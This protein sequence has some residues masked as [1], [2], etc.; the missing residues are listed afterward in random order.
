MYELWMIELVMQNHC[1]WTENVIQL[2]F[3]VIVLSRDTKKLWFLNF[4]WSR[5]TQSKSLTAIY[6]MHICLSV[7]F[8]YLVTFGTFTKI[9]VQQPWTWPE[10]I[11]LQIRKI[12]I[13][14]SK[15]KKWHG[16]MIVKFSNYLDFPPDSIFKLV[17]DMKI[18]SWLLEKKFF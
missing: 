2:Y 17:F 8:Y 12:R 16:K 7:F 4:L 6:T 1:C 3:F 15:I 9:G 5:L 14:I 11:F 13:S 10:L 18:L